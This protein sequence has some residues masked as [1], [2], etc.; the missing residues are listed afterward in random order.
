MQNRIDGQANSDR[1]MVTEKG[2][3]NKNRDTIAKNIKANV[4]VVRSTLKQTQEMLAAIKPFTTEVIELDKLIGR[5]LMNLLKTMNKI[6]K[7][8]GKQT[9]K[10]L[11]LANKIANSLGYGNKMFS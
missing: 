4:G 2:K 3:E 5:V 7:D 10:F 1:D 6:Y 8:N 11:E 9:N